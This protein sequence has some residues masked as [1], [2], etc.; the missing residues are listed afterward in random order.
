MNIDNSYTNM[1]KNQMS[2]VC[3]DESGI[4]LPDSQTNIAGISMSLYIDGNARKTHL[5]SQR[6]EVKVLF[7]W[8]DTF[9]FTIDNECVILFY[10]QSNMT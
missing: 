9:L 2:V 5:G 6:A 8:S 4:T 7:G 3:I 10:F 1:Y